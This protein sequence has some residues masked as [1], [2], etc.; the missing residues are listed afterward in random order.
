MVENP[1]FTVGIVIL[2]HSSGDISIFGFGGQITISGC[3][4]LSQSAGD[5]LCGSPWS[6]IRDLPLEFRRYLLQLQ[7]YN[8]IFKV[9]VAVWL[10]PV[11]EIV[12]TSAIVSEI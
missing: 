12:V 8:Y 7:W 3:R 4:S 5:T 10:F 9:L 1:R 11:V 2:C 6:K